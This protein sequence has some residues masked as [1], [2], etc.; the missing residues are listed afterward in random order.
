M[1]ATYGFYARTLIMTEVSTFICFHLDFASSVNVPS[2][3][4]PENIKFTVFLFIAT[5]IEN[6]SSKLTK[7]TWNSLQSFK[8][9]LFQKNN[10]ILN[11]NS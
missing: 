2:V 9:S 7:F 4:T 6:N 5:Q 1:S 8:F 10:N 3:V 11:T